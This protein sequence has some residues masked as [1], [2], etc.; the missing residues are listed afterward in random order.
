[1]YITETAKRKVLDLIKYNDTDDCIEYPILNND[2]YGMIQGYDANGKKLHM[3]A[4]RISYQLFYNDDICSDDIICHH[5][6][7][8]KCINP[9]HLFKGTHADNMSDKVKKGRQA[10]GEKNGRYIDGRCSDRIVHKQ[11][12]VGKLSIQQVMEVRTLLSE[13]YSAPEI[14][15]ILNITRFNVYDIIKGKSYKDIR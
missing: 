2:G 12:Y 7:N 15:K 13:G 5:C 1:M 11:R 3:F 10:K 9:K 8:P 14:A 4:H 6:D